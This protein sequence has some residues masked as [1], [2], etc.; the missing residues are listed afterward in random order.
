M[1]FF[2][3]RNAHRNTM[4]FRSIRFD[5]QTKVDILKE[6]CVLLLNSKDSVEQLAAEKYIRTVL[7]DLNK[8]FRHEPDR[9]ELLQQLEFALSFHSEQATTIRKLIRK[10]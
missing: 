2:K 1:A 10:L 7:S 8:V 6:Q 5:R 4:H 9:L 3:E